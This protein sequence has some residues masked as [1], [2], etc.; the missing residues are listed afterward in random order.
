M[1]AKSFVDSNI[2]I[3][4]RD[5]ADRFRQAR[6]I[7]LIRDLRDQERLVISVQVISEFREMLRR[8]GESQV[9]LMQAVDSML[10]FYPVPLT[11]ETIRKANSLSQRHSISWWDAMIVGSALLADCRTLYTEDLQS[12]SRMEGLTIVNPFV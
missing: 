6:A 2:W 1:T 10:Q 9:L 11:A 7:S 8:R 5:A 12:G 3:Y 4:A